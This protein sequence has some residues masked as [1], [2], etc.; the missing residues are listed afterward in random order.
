[1]LP[2]NILRMIIEMN[3]L[4]A[5][6]CISVRA[7][8]FNRKRFCVVYAPSSGTFNNLF[9]IQRYMPL[10]NNRKQFVQFL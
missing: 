5:L 1:M 7:F 10:L 3:Q 8:V 2:M 4:C 9:H 6:N